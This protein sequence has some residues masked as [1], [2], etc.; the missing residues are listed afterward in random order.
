MSVMN[1]EKDDRR[2]SGGFALIVRTVLLLILLLFVI[3]V[4][5]AG[6]VVLVD[7]IFMPAFTHLGA[8]VELPD[9]VD[10]EFYRARQILL[11]LGLELERTGEE[12]SPVI[13]EGKIIDQSPAPFTRVKRG[14]MVGV[15]VSRGPEE[16]IIPDLRRLPEDQAKARLQEFGLT[17]GSVT[18]RPDNAPN[19]TVIDQRPEPNLKSLRNRAVDLVISSGPARVSIPIPRLINQ[20]LDGALRTIRDLQGKVWIEWIENSANLPLTVIGQSPEPGISVAGTPVF[21]LQVSIPPGWSITPPDTVGIGAPP[22]WQRI[23]PVL[24]PPGGERP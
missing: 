11:E 3:G 7:R 12:F 10:Q 13:E 14:R 17:L 23:R 6:G 24:P 4:F 18:S 2:E 19:G 22:P 20:G 15:V 5:F 9:V 1:G 16:I 8:E 21:D